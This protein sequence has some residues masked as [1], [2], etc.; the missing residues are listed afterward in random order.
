MSEQYRIENKGNVHANG[1]KTSYQIYE[2]YTDESGG[3]AYVFAGNGFATGHNASD[4]KC[5]AD[6]IDQVDHAHL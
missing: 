4:E 2:R 3:Q 6:F 1:K 5:I